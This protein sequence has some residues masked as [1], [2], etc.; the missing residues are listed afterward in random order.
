MHAQ[1]HGLAGGS[2][3]ASIAL[4]A[5]TLVTA[6]ASAQ[7]MK[8]TYDAAGN[9]IER[10]TTSGAA[11]QIVR[12]PRPNVVAPG[13]AASFVVIV[14]DTRGVSYQWR[15][16]GS[17][18]TGATTDTLLIPS[19]NSS[20]QG[21]YSVL[22]TNSSGSVTSNPASLFLDTNENG[23][24]DPW[25]IANFGALT[26]QRASGDA[27]ADGSSNLAEFLDGTNP[28][29]SASYRARLDI[30]ADGG[31][32]TAS[33]ASDSYALGQ[34]VA[35]T[36][37]PSASTSFFGW[38]GALSGTVNPTTVTMNGNRSV[39]AHF[40]CAPIPPGAIA[41]FGA[42]ADATDAMASHS[43]QFFSGSTPTTPRLASGVL[44]NAFDFDGSVHVRI[45]DAPALRPAAFAIEAWVYPKLKNSGWQGILCRGSANN[46]DNPYC[47]ALNNGK[48]QFYTVH[49]S[50]N[51]QHLIQGLYDLPLNQWSHLAGTF[52][53]NRKSFYVNGDLVGSTAGHAAIY[54]AA[55]SVAVTIGAD[56][57]QGLVAVPFTGR[58]DEAA[59]YS[60]ALTNA[61]VGQ[62]ADAGP[63][64]KCS[65]PY[66][67][68]VALPGG[69]VG[70]PYAHTL[71]VVLA[72][73]PVT[74]SLSGGSL[75]PGLSLSSTGTFG[76]TPTGSGSYSFSVR[77]VDSAGKFTDQVYGIEVDTPL[78]PPS[79]LV[80]WWRGE[81]DASDSA[82]SH[83]GSFQNENTAISPTLAA[84]FVGGAMSF[85]GS[86]HVTVPDAPELR[87]GELTLETWV[88][89]TTQTSTKQEIVARAFSA[90]AAET[91]GLGLVNRVPNFWTQHAV[92]G[93]HQ[94]NAASA[95]LPLN[96]WTHLAATFDGAAKRLYVNGALVA[97]ASNL[98]ALSYAGAAVPITIGGLWSATGASFEYLG[99]LDE[100]SVYEQALSSIDINAIYA[101]G[102][103]GKRDEGPRFVTHVELPAAVVAQPYSQSIEAE[104]GAGT[105][106]YWINGGT[107]PPGMSL[108]EDGVLSGT[109]IMP[110]T[111]EFTV[112]VMD[113]SL[114][115]QQVYELDVVEAVP[116][117]A[118][119]IGWW[120]GESDASDS[121]GTHNGTFYDGTTQA[122][123]T[124]A[125]GFVGGALS[126][127]G[128]V[129]V[130]VPDT[131][132]LRPSEVTLEAWV[133]PTQQASATRVIARAFS[134]GTNETY[135]LGFVDG[136][137]NFWTRH[138]IAG[139]K[140]LASPTRVPL[141]TWTHV[142]ATFDGFSKRLYVD[143]GL[144]ASANG[145]DAL[146]YDTASVPTTI[147]G[148]WRPT[149][150]VS[151][152]V[153]R[154]D[155]VSVY[156]RALGGAELADVF[157]A[158][159]AGKRVSGP[160][161]SAAP[162][163][164]AGV[165]GGTYAN[166]PLISSGGSA[167]VLVAVTGGALPPGLVLSPSGT[168]SGTPTEAGQYWWEVTATDSSGAATT[169]RFS[170]DVEVGVAVPLGALAWWRAEADALDSL[171]AS[172]GTLVGGASFALGN[173]GQAFSFDGVDDR[174]SIPES[175]ATDISRMP[176]W[177]IEAWVF[178]FS[179]P[180]PTRATIYSEGRWRASLGINP[181]TGKLESALNNATPLV[182]DGVLQLGAW[183]H[184]V[185]TYDSSART[186]YIN[187][188]VAGRG[189]SV[190]VGS[191][192]LG[193]GIGALPSNPTSSFL[194][195]KIDEV[196][197]YDRV[198][199]SEE[200]LTAYHAGATG[201]I[202]SSQ[203]AAHFRTGQALP[204]AIVGEPYDE[205]LTSGSAPPSLIFEAVGG[206]VPAGLELASNGALSGVPEKPGQHGFLIRA[207]DATE[208]ISE[209][210]FTLRVSQGVDA[211]SGLVAW[212]RAQSDAQDSVGTNHGTVTNGA[213]FVTG[214]VGQCFSFDGVDDRVAIPESA[215][216]DLSRMA[217]WTIEAWVR[218]T[219]FDT[220]A[221][222]TIYSE[223]LF[224]VSLGLDQYTGKLESRINNESHDFNVLSSNTALL[225]NTWSHVALSYDGT[226]RVLYLNGSETGRRMALPINDDST[227]AAIGDVPHSP[228]SSRFQGRID[229]LS[230][231]NRALF[232][233][234]VAAIYASGHLGKASAGGP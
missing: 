183:N 140:Q 114:A 50:P 42:Q 82:G 47:F 63:A 130:H 191:D 55:G 113:A 196:V 3:I 200:V 214:E 5:V 48:P 70:V 107:L 77:V 46:N 217:A 127:S 188:S 152:F 121:M 163:L 49:G 202:G 221:R 149:G 41:Y 192:D 185:L 123:P 109:P 1:R 53:G 195:G 65:S 178:P 208:T 97:S 223:G 84:G 194:P 33:P 35:L 144:V 169:E 51:Q 173:T 111:F 22:V 201:K 155:E 103:L 71:S 31:T 198:L 24:P 225:L 158:S 101:A 207:T 117:P 37:T 34:V 205:D 98:D 21:E 104:G 215:A 211:Q 59:I 190:P 20:D 2:L 96:V 135:G 27:D 210:L 151:R 143:G 57:D 86:V 193:A 182:S 222:A 226:S 176:E 154:L 9:L 64:S 139:T 73:P 16:N 106:S 231:Y 141:N 153:G 90:G 128:N 52:D 174:V 39:V 7:S 67:T 186:F 32:V 58:V 81:T 131:V 88:Y 147:G 187:G 170:V 17:N 108:D 11:P 15:F 180:S 68:T 124:L 189:Q 233:A 150:S 204:D 199:G 184:V 167:P 177:T 74:F 161:F 160:R 234:E 10:T 219:T 229:E 126:F 60:R 30:T 212:W 56:L 19:A 100:V 72:T 171:G 224:R 12:H 92:A 13:D 137:P 132:D 26:S 112:A 83:D 122:S 213:T 136:F 43:G 94:L 62:I 227:G 93:A 175:A 133:Y 168:I 44:G 232:P 164:P 85:D 142:A 23:L 95:A 129:A 89:P 230:I 166:L 18:I 75:P 120:R 69:A 165:V 157:G 115:S 110:G 148:A 38:S 179:F 61:E 45:P 14:S 216:I 29:A 145:L 99:R 162:S 116:P 87:P 156:G 4:F 36:A 172:D 91:Y 228:N 206:A 102:S 118:G 134:S 105:L 40:R 146:L 218:P 80:G 203:A 220:Q 119:L 78:P 25:E 138:V 125:A 181:G 79:G 159:F 54:Y 66:F 8:F 28:T 209:K 197:I 6:S 76:G